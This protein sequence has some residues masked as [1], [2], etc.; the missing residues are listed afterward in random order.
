[1]YMYFPSD[2][3]LD[4]PFFECFIVIFRNALHL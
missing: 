1:M 2:K 3:K 4:I